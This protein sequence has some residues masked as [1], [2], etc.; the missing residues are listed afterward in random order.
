MSSTN[1]QN[2]NSAPR[3]RSK[4]SKNTAIDSRLK[5]FSFAVQKTQRGALWSHLKLKREPSR[6]VNIKQNLNVEFFELKAFAPIQNKEKPKG[7]G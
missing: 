4:V 3:S 1:K 2:V 7:G 6:E 5:K